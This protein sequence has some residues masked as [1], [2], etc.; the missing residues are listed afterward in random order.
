MAHRRKHCVLCNIGYSVS[1]Y[2]LSEEHKSVCMM[3]IGNLTLKYRIFD[4]IHWIISNICVLNVIFQI[5][6]TREDSN[7]GLLKQLG[8]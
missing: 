1:K 3:A 7:S 2:L 6:E 8:A 5:G 4:N